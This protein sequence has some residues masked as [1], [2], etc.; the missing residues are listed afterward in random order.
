MASSVAGVTLAELLFGVTHEGAVDVAD[1]L[2]RRTRV[3]LIPEE[4]C[5]ACNDITLRQRD[6]ENAAQPA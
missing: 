2:D 5:A 4:T 1:L 6:R 3:G